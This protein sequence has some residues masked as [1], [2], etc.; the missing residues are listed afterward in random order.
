MAGKKYFTVSEVAT[1]AR[2]TTQA[3]YKA[4]DPPRCEFP[5]SIHFPR[6]HMLS[7]ADVA[8]FLY[9]RSLRLEELEEQD[10]E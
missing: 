5:T 2:V 4:I 3:I 1:M 7:R 8:N 6:H 10:N 9:G